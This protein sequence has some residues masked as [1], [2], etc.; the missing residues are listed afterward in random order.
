MDPMRL[1]QMFFCLNIGFMYANIYLIVLYYF[2][3]DYHNMALG[4]RGYLINLVVYEVHK[5]RMP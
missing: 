5:R 3:G 1:L 4:V 2:L